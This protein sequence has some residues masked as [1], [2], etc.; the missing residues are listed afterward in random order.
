MLEP[1]ETLSHFMEDAVRARL[2]WRLAQLE[3]IEQ[4]LVERDRARRA[5]D[6]VD[7][8]DVVRRLDAVVSAARRRSKRR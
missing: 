4:G 7:S 3:F 1:D 8:A 2:E 6:Y 5:G